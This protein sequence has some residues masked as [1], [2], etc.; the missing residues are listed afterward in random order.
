M[1][2]YDMSI[3]SYDI[4]YGL[5]MIETEIRDSATLRVPAV[6]EGLALVVT[7]YDDEKAV[8]MN[9]AD[10][11]RLAALD[12]ALELI[13]EAEALPLDALALEAHRLE[14]EPSQQIEDPVAIRAL[15]GL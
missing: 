14:D 1:I 4:C 8:V 3:V 11:R 10:F 2:S 9:P 6:A 15:L 13:G 7:R 12:A 5:S